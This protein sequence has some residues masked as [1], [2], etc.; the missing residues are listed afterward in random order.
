MKEKQLQTQL[1]IASFQP[2]NGRYKKKDLQIANICT[3]ANYAN[4]LKEKAQ[5]QGDRTF[6]PTPLLLSFTSNMYTIPSI[7]SY[8]TSSSGYSVAAGSTMG[9][10]ITG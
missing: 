2:V 8:C 3:K 6:L 5:T 9:V 4:V 1:Y 10:G 7:S